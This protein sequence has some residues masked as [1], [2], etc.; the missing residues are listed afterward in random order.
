MVACTTA[1]DCRNGQDRS[2]L[3]YQAISDTRNGRICC[4]TSLE[5]QIPVLSWGFSAT[6]HAQA[7]VKRGLVL[8]VQ[9]NGITVVS[10]FI[11]DPSTRPERLAC[12]HIGRG[13]V[14]NLPV[15][16]DG[17]IEA[18]P[19][20]MPFLVL[21]MPEP[22]HTLLHRLESDDDEPWRIDVE[23]CWEVDLRTVIFRVREM[24]TVN[25]AHQYRPGRGEAHFEQRLL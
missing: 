14:L 13:Q 21:A 20:L 7:H 24:G 2:D 4:S 12:Y 6:T 18:S 22:E 16:H 19:S 9:S 3:L 23:P 15:T 8:G 1:R 10:D 17:Y 5:Q 25:C 11:V